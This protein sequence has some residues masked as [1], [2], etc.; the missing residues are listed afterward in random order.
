MHVMFFITLAFGVIASIIAYSRGRNSL[1]WFLTGLL[2]GPCALVVAVLPPIV[3]EGLFKK[4]PVCAEIIQDEAK[5]CRYC[6]FGFEKVAEN[7][8]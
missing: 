5:R 7:G 6:G 8:I 1:G 4:C 2:I 3:R